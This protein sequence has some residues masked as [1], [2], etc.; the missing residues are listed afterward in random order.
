MGTLTGYTSMQDFNFE[1]ITKV[2]PI[3]TMKAIVD[4]GPV[5]RTRT[6][7]FTRPFGSKSSV[8]LKVG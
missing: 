3:E 1:E 7:R 6:R 5:S 8:V 4:S 2:T